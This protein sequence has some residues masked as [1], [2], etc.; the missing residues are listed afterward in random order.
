[1]HDEKKKRVEGI[2]TL[3]RLKVL[4]MWETEIE[5]EEEAMEFV[6]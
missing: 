1:M 6:W 3:K 2:L 4:C 5:I